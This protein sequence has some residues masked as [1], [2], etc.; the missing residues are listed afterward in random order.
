MVD[1]V[2]IC[3]RIQNAISLRWVKIKKIK[4]KKAIHIAHTELPYRSNPLNCCPSGM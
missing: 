2:Y 3:T 1:I 4:M